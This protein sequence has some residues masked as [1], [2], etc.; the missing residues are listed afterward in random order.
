MDEIIDITKKF[1]GLNEE[2]EYITQKLNKVWEK[3]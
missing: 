2:L 3:Y 1:S